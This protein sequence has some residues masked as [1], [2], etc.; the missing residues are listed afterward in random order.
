[1]REELHVQAPSFCDAALEKRELDLG[2]RATS[3]NGLE[4]LSRSLL[5]G[6]FE[7]VYFPYF[8][9][10]GKTGLP[11]FILLRSDGFFICVTA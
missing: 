9:P 7:T 2:G 6:N 8:I 11:D 10:D 5:L 1:M 3:E 4:S